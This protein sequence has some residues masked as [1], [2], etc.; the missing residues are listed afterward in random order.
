[1][2]SLHLLRNQAIESIEYPFI[3]TESNFE[4]ASVNV[5]CTTF[6]FVT[7]N[8]GSLFGFS[9]SSM[10]YVYTILKYIRITGTT[11]THIFPFVA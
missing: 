6:T 11:V 8:N 7:F 3:R 4:V 10:H 9:E 1:M 5:S 2:S